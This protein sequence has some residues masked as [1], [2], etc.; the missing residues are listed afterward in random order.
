MS[1]GVDSGQASG[2]SN[3]QITTENLEY[4]Q[5]LNEIQAEICT[6]NLTDSQ[7]STV[8][9]LINTVSQHLTEKDYSGAQRDIDGNPVPNGQGGFFDH[10]HE[11]QDS[12]RSLTKIKRKLEG[13]LKNPNLGSAEKE[14][15]ENSLKTA[16][17]HI[18]RIDK[19]FEKYGGI[20]NWK[21]K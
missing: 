8:L 17:E 4:A 21:K 13:S 20:L 1:S 6:S 3:S 5:K 19:M 7:K 16:N 14:I 12:Y 10:I 2:T 15:L 9:T 18:E 11:M